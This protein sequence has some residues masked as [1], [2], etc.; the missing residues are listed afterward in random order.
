MDGQGADGQQQPEPQCIS[1]AWFS[2]AVLGQTF[3]FNDDSTV[4]TAAN[5]TW[6]TVSGS[7]DIAAGTGGAVGGIQIS[8]DNGGYT[9]GRGI[10]LDNIA[11][12]V[13][14]I[15]EPAT[16]GLM[17]LFGAGAIFIRRRFMM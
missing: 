15:P 14:T 4:E 8:T 16:L 10:F 6:T 9:S 7:Y 17:V 1:D 2:S 11:V 5:G 13:T 12:D 3:S